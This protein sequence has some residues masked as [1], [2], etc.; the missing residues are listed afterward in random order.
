MNGGISTLPVK[1]QAIRPTTPSTHLSDLQNSRRDNTL[2]ES[3][4]ANSIIKS[5]TSYSYNIRPHNLFT[6][7]K[8]VSVTT[9][10]TVQEAHSQQTVVVV[11]F[12]AAM[13]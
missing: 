6:N 7:I 10:R 5:Q 9:S 11:V 8:I 12:V 13:Q 3:I 4:I 2:H 1:M